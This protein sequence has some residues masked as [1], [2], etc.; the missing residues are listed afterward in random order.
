MNRRPP[1]EPRRA[2]RQRRRE[3]DRM[4]AVVERLAALIGAGV[5]PSQAWRY[6][7]E[8]EPHPFVASVI[9]RLD[10]GAAVTDAIAG[11]ARAVIAPRAPLGDGSG[12]AAGGAAHS[13]H[14][15]GLLAAAWEVATEA[16]AP[17]GRCLDDLAE[18]FRDLAQAERQ[19]ASALASPLATSR[20][21]LA[22]PLV[23]VV[24]G[25]LLGL[26]T[27][28]ILVTTPLGFG[29]LA[30]GA[31]LTALGAVWSRALVQRA[32]PSTLAPGFFLD[33][34]A[35]A[36]MG[37]SSLGAARS[38]VEHAVESAAPQSGATAI[39]SGGGGELDAVLTLA[40]R[41]GAPVGALLRREAVRVR[42]DAV[43]EA[44]RRTE[45]LGVWLMMPLG[46]CVLPAFV[47][48]SVVPLLLGALPAGFL[49]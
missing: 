47:L 16:G 40:E 8:V 4:S 23:T 26:D 21:V 37:G 11:A 22:L 31:V 5:A 42:R 30:A 3:A 14:G 12:V 33:L 36:V 28:R 48:L 18:S 41:S 19:T 27:L 39:A 46:L 38:L 7:A 24:G 6:L 25:T 35:V 45:A 29:C 44:H 15:W 32:R 49:L 10:A 1:V 9:A 13:Q 20:L 34:M 43:A 2:R 17:L